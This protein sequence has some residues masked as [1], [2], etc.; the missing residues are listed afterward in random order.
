M[1]PATN[2]NKMKKLFLFACLIGLYGVTQAQTSIKPKALTT[3]AFGNVIDTVDNTELHVTTPF[4]VTVWKAGATAQVQVL[5]ISGTVA[6]TLGF[7][8]SM[9]GG[10]GAT[11]WTL[12]GSAATVTDASNSYG[13]N[14]TVAWKYYQVRWTGTGTM[15]ASMRPYIQL[16]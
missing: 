2:T 9:S 1:A 6:G 10:T 12:I 11:E 15:S 5:K 7:Y 13:F 4:E 16:Y 3:T 14:T 8:G